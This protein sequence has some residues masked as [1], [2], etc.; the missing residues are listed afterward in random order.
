MKKL[1]AITLAFLV[2]GAVARAQ[3]P[4]VEEIV[5]KTNATSYYQGQDGKA[6]VKM[7]ITDNQGRERNR[8]FT[9]LRL[10]TD[11]KNEEQKF[12]VYFH[13]PADVREMVFMVWKH[14]GADDD[15]W[16]YLPALDVVKRIAASDERTSFV[17][18]N[19]FYEDVS[20]RGLEEDNHELVET[21][22]T[23]YVLKNTPKDPGAVE[24]DSY[25]MWIHKGTFIPVKV[26]YE[27]GGNVYR[28]AE[29]LEVKDIQGYKTVVK[30]RMKD[31]NTGG[32]TV[33]EY[34]SV[35]Y[36]QGIPEDIFT[37]R[38]LRRAPREYID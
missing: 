17:G 13:R 14:V 3:E 1:F 23:Y 11:D 19:F 20:G 10:N 34:E 32:E 8:E 33:L 9:I 37:E 6:R 5:Q 35:A 28:V 21:T 4:S 29:A 12:Y 16:L 27:K 2:A 26:E 22:D 36:D 18:S 24:F 15:R 30:S 7:T 31:L 25:T 38:Y